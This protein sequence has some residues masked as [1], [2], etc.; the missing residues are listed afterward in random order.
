MPRMILGPL[1]LAG[2]MYKGEELTHNKL[3]GEYLLNGKT[4][5]FPETV[6]KML[7]WNQI[8]AY[9]SASQPEH[10]VS[11]RFVREMGGDR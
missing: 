6:T 5:V 10:M 7:E 1:G 9:H 2:R 11:F 8:E 4:P 3:T